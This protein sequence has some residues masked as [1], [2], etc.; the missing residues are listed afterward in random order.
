[1]KFS[2]QHVTRYTYA[3]P[4]WE[5]FNDAHLCPV[6]DEL[7][8]CESFTL[9]ILPQEPRVLRRLDFYTNQV[10]HFEVMEP[11]DWLEVE[12]S[13]LVETMPDTRDFTV[14]CPLAGL[15]GLD[16]DER[17]YDFLAGSQRVLLGPMF[18]HEATEIVTGVEDVRLRVE[19]LMAYIFREFRYAP[20]STQVE[21]DVIQV[22]KHK[23][24]VCQD[25]AHVMIA[26]CRSIKIPARYV[27]G[28]FYVEKSV[29]GSADDN[30]ASHAWVECFLPGIGWVGYDP[31]HNRR[32]DVRYIKLAIGRDYVDVRPLAGTYRGEAVAEME[33]AVQVALV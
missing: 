9:K 3:N 23:R 5:S 27:S 31:T 2:V 11:H 17:Y 24:G 21:T 25:F 28:Y 19:A 20:G 14:P 1:M 15:T 7:Q 18:E 26:L 12:A 16:R 30:S 4:V 22:F 13:S 10:H 8:C 33:V 29:S 6:S 32:A